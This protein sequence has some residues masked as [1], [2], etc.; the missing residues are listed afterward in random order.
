MLAGVDDDGI[1]HV[2]SDPIAKPSK[3]SDVDV[4]D[5]VGQLDLDAQYPAIRV[6]DYQVYFVVIVAST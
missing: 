2:F 6:L 4:F 5:S 1:D 3:V